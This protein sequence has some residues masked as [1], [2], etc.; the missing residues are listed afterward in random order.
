[1]EQVAESADRNPSWFTSVNQRKA[2][3]FPVERVSWDDAQEFIR[4]L[5]D[6]P[7]ERRAGRV[8][9]LPTEAEWEYAC[10]A[11]AGKEEPFSFA[12]PSASCSSTQANF[13]GGSP[14]GGGAKK[15]PDLQRTARVGSY[16][17]NAFGLYDMHGNVLEWCHDWYDAEA[18]KGKDRTDPR[19]AKAG[20]YRV[21]RG[22]AWNYAGH[23]LRS[24]FR[25][26][27]QPDFRANFIGFRV[28]CDAR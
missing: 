4:K 7:Q 8:Y 6:L 26:M 23:S 19:G 24:G 10:R 17:A 5:N 12:R 22:G 28:A 1:M 11:G 2:D 3:D 9:R 13:I 15:G 25:T 18:Y 20:V 21:L 14:F 16:E 27:C